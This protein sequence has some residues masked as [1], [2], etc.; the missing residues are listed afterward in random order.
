MMAQGVN[1]PAAPPAPPPSQDAPK[2]LPKDLPKDAPKEDAN[3]QP[4]EDKR[5][6]GVLPNNRMTEASAPFHPITAK[7]KITIAFKDSFDIPVYPTAGLFA[8][9]YQIENQNPS[10]GQGMAGYAKRFATAYGDQMI[11]N[12]MTEGFFPAVLHE[13]PRYFRLGEGGMRHRT[14]YALSQIFVTRL[15]NGHKSFNIEEWGGNATAVA[16]SQAYYPDTRDANDAAQK[17]LIQC[18]TDAFSNVLKEFW[19]DVKKKLHKKK[20]DQH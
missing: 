19:P 1:P 14:F 9:L 3:G 7:Q 17:L 6:Y 10:F 11:G 12:M 16:I 8:A 15:D 2:D 5:I 4:I 20:D 18:A 13:D